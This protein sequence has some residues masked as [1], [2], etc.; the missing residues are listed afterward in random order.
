MF[1]RHLTLIFKVDF[2]SPHTRLRQK[3]CRNAAQAPHLLTNDE[4]ARRLERMR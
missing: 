4:A 2:F 1:K 3:R